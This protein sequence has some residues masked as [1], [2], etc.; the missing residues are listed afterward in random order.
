VEA[1]SLQELLLVSFE[2]R[3]KLLVKSRDVGVD[4]VGEG[5]DHLFISEFIFIENYIF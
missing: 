1:V 5:D 2:Y 4:L 3:V